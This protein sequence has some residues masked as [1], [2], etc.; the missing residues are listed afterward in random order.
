TPR[1]LRRENHRGVSQCPLVKLTKKDD[2]NLVSPILS[3]RDRGTMLSPG[4]VHLPISVPPGTSTSAGAHPLRRRRPSLAR[5]VLSL[6]LGVGLIVFP[7]CSGRQSF[8]TGGPSMGQ[9][10]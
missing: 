2:G 1:R 10:K 9:M 8:L 6:S 3:Q 7:G 5:G 4:S